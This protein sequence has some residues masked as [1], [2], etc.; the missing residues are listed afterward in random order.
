MDTVVTVERAFYY[1][2]PWALVHGACEGQCKL[3]EVDSRWDQFKKGL[4]WRA[5]RLTKQKQQLKT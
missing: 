5:Q 1:F 2:I 3:V 4:I